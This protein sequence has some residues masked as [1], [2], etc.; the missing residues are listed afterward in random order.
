MARKPGG[1]KNAITHGA[2]AEDLILPGESVREFKLLHRGLIEEWK[3]IGALEEDTVLTLAHCIWLKRRVD[4]FYY[5]EATWLQQHPGDEQVTHAIVLAE[6]LDRT[7]TVQD[8]NNVIFKLPE[9][10][11]KW[12]ERKVPRS[13]FKDHKSWILNLKSGIQYL[14]AT[15]DMIIDETALTLAFEAERAAELRELTSKKLL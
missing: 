10:Y 11:K 14:L 9:F 12:L 1:Q 15:A 6:E 3:P 7:Q 13:K 8:A 5:W 2:Y 4:R